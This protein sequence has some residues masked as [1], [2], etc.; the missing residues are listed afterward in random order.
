MSDAEHNARGY[1]RW[2]AVYDD[3]AN[4]TVAC[5]DAIVP[6]LYAHWRGARVLE[7]GCG[8]GRHTVRLVGLG[9]DVTGIDVSAG[10][11]AKAR[12]K[13]EGQSFTAIHGD[14]MTSVALH[15]RTFDAVF[16]SL[17]LE[18]VKDLEGFFAKV[19]AHLA[20]SGQALLSDIHPAR[21]TAGVLA[22]F[23]L[24]GAEEEVHLASHAHA[25]GAVEAAAEAA[26]LALDVRLDAHG[27]PELAARNERWRRHLGRPMVV[28]WRLRLAPE[29]RPF[30]SGF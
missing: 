10:M 4:P 18:H 23:R 7:I 8:T 19:A 1:D 5:D 29:T 21:S 17:V 12:E 30:P 26:G 28:V 22:H 24:P 6:V 27:T 11:L 2:A 13:L 20:P 9:N 16:S 3:Y 14:F 25:P 15:G